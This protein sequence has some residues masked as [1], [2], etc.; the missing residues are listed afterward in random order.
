VRS[1]ARPGRGALRQPIGTPLILRYDAD[2]A[3]SEVVLRAPEGP[4]A[5]LRPRPMTPA[6]AGAQGPA[7]L[8]VESAPLETAGLYGVE[9]KSD[10]RSDRWAVAVN[11][12][13]AESDLAP[14][15]TERI[16]EIFP[17]AR[18]VEFRVPGEA[19]RAARE[20]RLGS[21]LKNPLLFLVLALVL[22][23]PVLANAVAFRRAR[24]AAARSAAAGAASPAE[25]GRS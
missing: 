13:L 9:E 10:G 22:L 18:M 6:G 15:S 4:P 24:E 17:S 12:D 5:T 20:F 1:L 23:E 7:S 25:G 21:E 8:T 16:G 19:S 11:P 3:P 14:L 2:A